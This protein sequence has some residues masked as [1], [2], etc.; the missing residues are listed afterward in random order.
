MGLPLGE[1]PRAE[2][3]G[4]PVIS[5]PSVLFPGLGLCRASPPRTSMGQNTP[6]VECECFDDLLSF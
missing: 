5:D 6:G 1:V 4:G 2:L 3:K